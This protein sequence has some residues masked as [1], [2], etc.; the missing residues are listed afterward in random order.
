MLV[1]WV[2]ALCSIVVVQATSSS[3]SSSSAPLQLVIGVDGGTESIRACCFNA[4]NGQVVGEACAVSYPT[5]HPHPGWAEQSPMDWWNC[6]GEAVRACVA[7]VVDVDNNHQKH[8]HHPIIIKAICVDTTCC[9]VV[10]LNSNYTPLRPSLLWMD[11]RSAPQCREIF[12]T[13]R[14]DL[15]LAVNAGGDGPL[16]AE[17]MTPKALWLKQCE[18]HVWE[19]AT[20]ILEYQDYINFKLTGIICASSCNAAVRWHWDGVACLE[21]GKGRPLSLYQKIGIPDLATKLPQTCYAMGQKIGVLTKDA[22]QQLHLPENLPVIQGG[23]DAFVG[24]VGNGCVAPGQLCLITGSSHLHCVVS[25]EPLTSKGIWGAYKGAPLSHL[26]FAE[27]GQSSTGS[28][29]RWAKNTLFGASEKSYMS[30]DDAASTISPGCDGLVAL[31]T[32]QGSRTPVTD[33]LARGALLGLTLSHTQAHI[34]RA[35]LEAVCFGTRACIEGLENAG[36]S[37]TEIIMAGGATRSPL[38]LQLHADITGKPVVVR[39]NSDA[40]LLGCAI[41][42]AVGAGIH[43]SVETAVAKMVRTQQRV[44][45]NQDVTAVYNNLFKQVYSKVSTA[46]RPVVH[47]I[48][49]LRG[50]ALAEA[51][52][53][54][55][56]D[57]TAKVVISPSLLACDWARMADEVERCVEAGATHLHV[58]IFVSEQSRLPSFVH[59]SC[60][61]RA[62]VDAYT[63]A[64]TVLLS[65]YA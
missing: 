23:P 26:N 49:N 48:A 38:W 5:T 10:A 16:S 61:A 14:G 63:V 15:A 27:G 57:S 11:Q 6:M 51:E 21:E 35:C 9:S 59:A 62:F 33:P 4:D 28:I 19:Q 22:A 52:E 50:G 65:L 18:P 29:M 36:H 56:G 43:D 64:D 44:E 2:I 25:S 41:L 54:G 24:M 17:W 1:V 32:F 53:E 39:E 46:A 34:W 12:E 8:H 13:A 58:D 30:F 42:A 20:H 55:R 3:S 37:C 60:F 40:P 47:A 45:P 7:S 31:E